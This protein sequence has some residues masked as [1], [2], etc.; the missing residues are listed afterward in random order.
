M[1]RPLTKR[2]LV[3]SQASESDARATFAVLTE[4]GRRLVAEA[5]P[6]ARALAAEILRSAL[7][8]HE[9]DVVADL[10]ARLG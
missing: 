8:S 3:T 1:L 2:R 10:M 7:R 9:V 6:T 4:G 5:T